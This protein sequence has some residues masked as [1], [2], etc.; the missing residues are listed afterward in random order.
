MEEYPLSENAWGR[1]SRDFF[2]AFHSY[3]WCSFGLGFVAIVW[4]G[5]MIVAPLYFIPANSTTLATGW[6]QGISFVG[7]MVVLLVVV[8]LVCGLF[9]P[10]RQRNEAR[11]MVI[12][13]KDIL[14][15][16]AFTSTYMDDATDFRNRLISMKSEALELDEYDRNHFREWCSEVS[17]YLLRNMP[18]ELQAWNHNVII[19]RRDAPLEEVLQACEAGYGILRSIQNRM[20]G[21]MENEGQEGRLEFS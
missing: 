3:G 10:Y 7:G 17:E 12:K 19:P 11:R 20:V 9:T 16:V 5:Y 21:W 1:T 4:E 6:I 13:Q 18:L 8:F 2:D 14:A 15:I